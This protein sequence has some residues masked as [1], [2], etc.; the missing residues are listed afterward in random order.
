MVL[1]VADGE[2][3]KGHVGRGDELLE[4]REA[5]PQPRE[6][7]GIRDHEDLPLR[8]AAQID[9]RHLGQLL[10]ALGNH[11]AGE[12][13][14][15]EEIPSGVLQR[16]V[17]KEGRDVR[18]AGLEHLGPV[19]ARERAHRAVDLLIDFDVEIVDVAPLL[20]RERHH[21]AAVT[22][23]AADVLEVSDLHEALPQGLHHG[24]VQLARRQVGGAHL[25]GHV[26]D[27]HVRN[28]RHGQPPDAHAAQH[29]EHQHRGAA[30]DPRL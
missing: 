20:E 24:V 11:V 4:L 6:R 21:G 18:G 7:L 28:Q 8:P 15:P 30:A 29:D 25:H 13:A 10:D 9:H 23:L 3:G 16:H 26:G 27:V 19:D 17:D 22:R 5:Q 14:H 1:A 12:F 2:V